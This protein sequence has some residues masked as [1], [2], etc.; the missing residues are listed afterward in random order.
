MRTRKDN[1]RN[2][3]VGAIVAAV[4]LTVPT[5][6]LVMPGCSIDNDFLGL[7][8]G[9]RDLLFGALAY[10]LLRG[11]ADDPAGQPIPGEDG[12]SC[13]DL[14]GNG[15]CDLE[16]EDITGDGQCGAQD[17]QGADGAT[18]TDGQDGTSGADGQDG[19]DGLPCWDLNGNGVAD[20]EED[21]DGNGAYDAL[22][23]VGADGAADVDGEPGTPGS[24]G[25]PGPAGPN[26]FDQ[27][28]DDFFTYP[29]HLPG[30]LEVDIV[31]VIEP[32]LGTPE[33]TA[34]DAGAI[35]F[36]FGIPTMYAAGNDVTMRLSFLRT[37]PLLL[38]ECLV[39]TLDAL[40]LRAGEGVMP[41][42]TRLWFKID[43]PPMG[44]E[45]DS[46]FL[47]VDIPVNSAG[48][49]EDPVGLN[50][51]E[52]L[53]FEIATAI[54]PDLSAWEDGGR[55]QLLGAE[56]YESSPGTSRL[57]G[58][59]V[60]TTADDVSCD[61]CNDNGVPDRIDIIDGTSDD[62]N[63]NDLPDEC[64]I[65]DGT[66]E[67][68]QPNG[69]PD[70][71]DIASEPEGVV[72]ARGAGLLFPLDGTYQLVD[73][74]GDGCTGN[75][76]AGGTDQHND[77]DSATVALPFNFNLYGALFNTTFV[78]NNGN[79]SFGQPYSTYTAS[80][81]P[82]ADFPMVAPFWGDVDT[83]Y[84]SNYVGDVWMRFFDADSSGTDETLVITWDSVGYYSQRGDKR[85]TFQLAISDGTNPI[86]GLGNTTCFSYDQ[87]EWTTGEASGGTDGLGGSPA[88]VGANAGNGVDYFQIGLF[89][90]QGTDW[91]GPGGSNDGVDF[92][93]GQQICYT[94]TTSDFNVP[95]IPANFPPGNAVTVA[96]SSGV[97]DL[98]LQFL[99]PEGNQ[100]TSV[101]H[102]IVVVQG[103]GNTAGLE[104]TPSTGNVATAQVA[105]APSCAQAGIYDLV[106]SATDDFDPPGETVVTLRIEVTCEGS[107]DCNE[108]GIPDECE[109][110]D[111]FKTKRLSF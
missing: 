9:Q 59:T 16:T 81:F 54:K 31:S 70:E 79:I 93:V 67:D 74:F 41:Y 105:W 14:D 80:G 60:F 33:N 97:L 84:T 27:F 25:A 91:D 51:S 75:R 71:C 109:L 63:D 55:Y 61:D 107:V 46:V 82:I 86:M 17:C 40:R 89:D 11:N 35:A 36:R 56:F 78:N 106:F 110:G 85:N 38:G 50:A 48:G 2:I 73:F 20:P 101:T 90:R 10:A 26:Y 62:C 44:P 22:D 47:L 58:A 37:G 76:C 100:T 99:S 64:D 21:V 43:V 6:V 13:W 65:A 39:F 15:N 98:D 3:V 108:N 28:I 29:D 32:A 103:A 23:C 1:R 4:L 57:N 45:P 53:A 19:V 95:P 96:G 102:E 68:C 77:D 49:L 7:E 104:I 12:L 24:T 30:E 111:N 72:A 66:S 34:G 18:G 88:T 92:L 5:W 8:D 69:I 94:T 87:M 52:M 42:G 83:G